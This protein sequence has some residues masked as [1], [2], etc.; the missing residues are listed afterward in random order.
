MTELSHDDRVLIVMGSV[1]RILF[2]LG[3]DGRILIVIVL[4]NND[5]ILATGSGGRERSGHQGCHHLQGE[6]GAGRSTTETFS[7]LK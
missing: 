7:H 1:D 6:G 2:V 4:I 3:L 5:R